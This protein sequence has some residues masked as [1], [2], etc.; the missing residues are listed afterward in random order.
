MYDGALIMSIVGYV[1]KATTGDL[2]DLKDL[3]RFFPCSTSLEVFFVLSLF[4]FLAISPS[5]GCIRR[6]FY[7]AFDVT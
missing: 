1:V 3:K 6:L 2:S 7:F 4:D 5:I